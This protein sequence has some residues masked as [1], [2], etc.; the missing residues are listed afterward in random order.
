MN[1]SLN[2]LSSVIFESIRNNLSQYLLLYKLGDE[3]RKN[4]F[5]VDLDC[6]VIIS[7]FGDILA[8]SIDWKV[9]KIFN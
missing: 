3:I 2:K 9:K 7:Y 1:I 8:L 5:L 6:Q 4:K